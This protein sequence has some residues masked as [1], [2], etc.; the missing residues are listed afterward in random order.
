MQLFISNDIRLWLVNANSMLCSR[1][2]NK[3]GNRGE[4]QCLIKLHELYTAVCHAVIY[5]KM[6]SDVWYRKADCLIQKKINSS[7]KIFKIT[8]MNIHIGQSK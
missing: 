1:Y 4:L 8:S 5:L 3:C 6:R 7:E 2:D